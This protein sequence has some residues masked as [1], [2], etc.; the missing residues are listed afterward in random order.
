MDWQ[1]WALVFSFVAMLLIASGYFVKKKSAFLLFQAAGLFF[2]MISYLCNGQ[3]FA[4]VG[5]AI[6]LIRLLIYY[7]HER[8]E[9]DVSIW[10]CLGLCA[11]SLLA[12]GVVNLWILKSFHPA[13]IL[14]LIA[15]IT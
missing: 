11:V 4:M 10:L 15:L 6:A 13:D 3:Y 8:K 9:M 2:L 7:V 1:D 5:L 14:Y 12:Y